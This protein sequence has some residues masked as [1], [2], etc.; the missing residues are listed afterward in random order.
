MINSDDDSIDDECDKLMIAQ[1]SSQYK[2][3]IFTIYTLFTFLLS[4]IQGLWKHLTGF[5]SG[6][7]M[8]YCSILLRNQCVYK[9]DEFDCYIVKFNK[10]RAN[11]QLWMNIYFKDCLKGANVF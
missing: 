9:C 2:A 10:L 5:V 11:Y 6:I 1:S 4:Y 3:G 7:D 8:V